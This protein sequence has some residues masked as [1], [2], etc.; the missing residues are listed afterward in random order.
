M[1]S[2]KMIGTGAA[3]LASAAILAFA[4]PVQAAATAAV[5]TGDNQ[6]CGNAYVNAPWVDGRPPVTAMG[7][8]DVTVTAVQYGTTTWSNSAVTDSDGRY[9]IQGTPTMALDIANGAYLILSVTAAPAGH[10]ITSANPW[11]SLTGIPTTHIGAA[12]FFVS[13]KAPPYDSAQYFNFTM[14]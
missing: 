5:P 14:S 12:I 2:V 13:H 3:A 7:L 4:G 9:C 6:L 1:M 10:S 8:A 11:K